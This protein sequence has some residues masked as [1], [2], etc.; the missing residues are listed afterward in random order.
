MR[1]PVSHHDSFD[2]LP[3]HVAGLAMTAIDPVSMLKLS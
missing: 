2:C 3:A 1:T